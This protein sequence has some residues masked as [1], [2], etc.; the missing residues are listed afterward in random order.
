MVAANPQG[1]AGA[2]VA[3]RL[4]DA[5]LPTILLPA[6]L[7]AAILLAAPASAMLQV[8]A[9]APA[10]APAE[11]PRSLLPDAF[12]E[13]PAPPPR[14]A[15]LIAPVLVAPSAPAGAAP[16]EAPAGI[17]PLLPD[18]P[19]AGTDTG[20]DAPG[21]DPFAALAQ[22]DFGLFG[23]L[24]PEAGGYGPTVFAGSNGRFL[25]GLAWRIDAPIASRWAAIT[26]RRALL[27]ASTAPDGIAFGTWVAARAWAL[28]RLGEIDG[29]KALVDAMPI[30]R[31][32]PALYRVAAQVALAGGDV[33]GLCPIAVTGQSLSRDPL[34]QLAVGMCAAIQGDDITAAGIFDELRGNGRN[35]GRNVEA[36]DVRLGERIA[37]LAGGAGRAS[38][39][40]W[41]E[42][43]PLTPFRYGVATAAGVAVPEDRLAALGPARYGW[44]VRNPAVAPAV[45]LDMLRQAAVIGTVS[46]GEL[47]S[48]VAA[49]SPQETPDA[50]GAA[51]LETEAGPDS[52]AGR[53]RTAFAGGSMAD[54]RAALRAIWASGEGAEAVG[55]LPIDDTRYGALLESAPAAARLSISPASAADSDRIIAALLAAGD[56]A[57]ARRWWRIAEGADAKVRGAAWAL[58]A[59]GAGG[60]PVSAGE[61]AGWRS[62]TGADARRAGLLIAALAGLGEATG[63]EWAD[64]RAEL[65]PQA[66]NS[67]SRA[68][69]AAAAAHHMGEVSLLAATGLQ[70]AWADVPPLH[71]YHIVAALVRTGRGAEAR[72]IAAEAMTR[73]Q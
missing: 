73:A 7:L 2:V 70:G 44:V 61:F 53:L 60:V 20:M 48:G 41:G 62:A 42:A 55:A 56:T 27:S 46:A 72:L 10:S 47:V 71:L 52:R 49:L 38:N 14:A 26:L 29:A 4:A 50:A 5:A 30:D 58:L 24:S 45:R 33:A 64:A 13:T 8:P 54:R 66:G 11:A 31:F 63:S 32:S 57:A 19:A 3:C 34:W 51:V 67:W 16:A 28:L 65:L 22:T 12:R 1:R 35:N 43:P 21:P 15:P 59:T 23:P 69:D 6:I 18:Q 9:G 39:I 36:F 37:T 68:I 40:N 25:A 17:A